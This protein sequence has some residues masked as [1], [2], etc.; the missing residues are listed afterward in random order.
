MQNE[1]AE[2]QKA[3]LASTQGVNANANVNNSSANDDF[4]DPYEE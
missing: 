4:I 2:L 1:D 3:L